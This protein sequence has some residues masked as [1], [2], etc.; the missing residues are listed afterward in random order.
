MHILNKVNTYETAHM[1]SAYTCDR[2]IPLNCSVALMLVTQVVA[3]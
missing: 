3:N 2:I 1:K